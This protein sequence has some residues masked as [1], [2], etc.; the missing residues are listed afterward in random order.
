MFA[1]QHYRQQQAT[2]VTT[3]TDVFDNQVDDWFLGIVQHHN[4]RDLFGVS[5]LIA[6]DHVVN[7]V[8]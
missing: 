1:R 5:P 3:R 7:R 2:V 8:I 4:R 6:H